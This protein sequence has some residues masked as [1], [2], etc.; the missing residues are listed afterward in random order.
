MLSRRSVEVAGWGIFVASA[1][2]FIVSGVKAGDVYS[3][4]GSTLFLGACFVFLVP[5]L[6]EKL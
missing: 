3:T 4:A 5:L 1:A 6:R 2:M